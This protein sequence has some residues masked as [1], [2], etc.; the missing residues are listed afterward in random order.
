MAMREYHRHPPGD[1]P[2]SG[3]FSL[4]DPM[5]RRSP[6]SSRSQLRHYEFRRLG[7]VSPE[8]DRVRL[9]VAKVDGVQVWQPAL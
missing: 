1:A 4:A 3:T 2:S 7:A 9:E 8:P 6:P 5:W